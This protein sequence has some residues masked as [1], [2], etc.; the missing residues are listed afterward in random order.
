M[1]TLIS[2]PKVATRPRLTL[3]RLCRDTQD[4]MNSMSLRV[5][6]VR[7]L[8]KHGVQKVNL[9]AK[10]IQIQVK[11]YLSIIQHIFDF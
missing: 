10:T 6:L 2:C 4:V 3:T 9:L 11:E 1:L 8:R 5:S 7:S